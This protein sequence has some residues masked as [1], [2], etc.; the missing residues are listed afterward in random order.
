LTTDE[1]ISSSNDVIDVS[2]ACSK[3]DYYSSSGFGPNPIEPLLLRRGAAEPGGGSLTRASNL[4]MAQPPTKLHS[5]SPLV[6][7]SKAQKKLLLA[8]AAA[9]ADEDIMTSNNDDEIY[10]FSPLLNNNEL[11]TFQRTATNANSSSANKYANPIYSFYQDTSATS[12]SNGSNR[13]S[14]TAPRNFFATPLPSEQ[15]HAIST[16]LRSNSKKALLGFTEASFFVFS[17]NG[18]YFG[19]GYVI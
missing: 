11:S 12:M 5:S 16:S 18:S 15:Q 8:A 14:M 19:P 6:K 4:L 9:S 17:T 10:G 3:L 7:A 2:K 1:E 13:E